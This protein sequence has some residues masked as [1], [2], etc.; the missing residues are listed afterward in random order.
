MTLQDLRTTLAATIFAL[1]AASPAGALPITIDTSALAGGTFTAAFD[2]IDGNGTDDTTIQIVGF[3][4]GGGSVSGLPTADTGASGSLSTAVTLTNPGPSI[5]TSL[6]QNFVAGTVF[7]FDW[8]V[9]TTNTG[10]IAP[11][12][13]V[14][15]IL[16]PATGLPIAT[17]DPSGAGALLFVEAS[18][19]AG[20]VAHQFVVAPVPEPATLLLVAAGALA[21]GVRRFRSTARRR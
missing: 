2:L 12:G 18:T 7:Q 16:D 17:S 8:T 6:L 4:F 9:T 15:S 5:I 13:F 21:L 10:G 20:P 3:D 19:A 1:I 11:D 14:F